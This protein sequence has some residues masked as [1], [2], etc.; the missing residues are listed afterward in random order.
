MCQLHSQCSI[1][2]ITKLLILVHEA[3]GFLS[4]AKLVYWPT[5]K[6]SFAHSSNFKSPK[7]P[8]WEVLRCANCSPSAQSLILQNY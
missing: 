3:Q 2:K 4:K 1:L 8:T 6:V 7:T 5:A